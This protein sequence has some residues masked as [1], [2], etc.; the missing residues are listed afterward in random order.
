[1]RTVA[2]IPAY[3]NESSIG[4]TVT[5]VIGDSR[6]E[7]VIVVDDASDDST[8]RAAASAGARVVRLPRNS[9]KGA[10][11]EA[12][13]AEAS[14]AE[15][16]LTVDADTRESAGKAL[17]LLAPILSGDADMAIG[18][19]PP[20]GSQGGFG[21][22]KKTTARLIK[23]AAGFEARE[24]LSGQRAFRRVVFESCRPLASGFAVDAA[25]TAD[26]V[27]L[28]F[29]VVELP[30]EMT[31]DHRGR[32]AAAF[33]HRARQGWHLLKAFAPRLTGRP[34]RR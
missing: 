22:V 29:R 16:L 11:L 12:G 14:G 34:R 6:I 9:G 28:G 20:A 27:R 3:R 19:L 4:A 23:M 30:V 32:G 15:I 31:H 2:V 25:L 24:P 13:F 21:L 7:D 5:A 17:D 10:A 18:V 33:A 26:A 1:M 8:A